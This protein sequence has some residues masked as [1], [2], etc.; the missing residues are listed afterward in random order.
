MGIH[1][2]SDKKDYQ[3]VVYMNYKK[4]SNYT[5]SKYLKF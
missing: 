3:I 1:L 2:A 4:M 5:I